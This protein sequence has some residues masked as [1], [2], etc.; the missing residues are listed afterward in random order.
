M[1]ELL[2]RAWP[3]MP[4]LETAVLCNLTKRQFVRAETVRQY[5]WRDNDSGSK[6]RPHSRG[7]HE[8]RVRGIEPPKRPLPKGLTI[9]ATVFFLTVRTDDWSFARQFIDL[10]DPIGQGPGAVMGRWAGDCLAVVEPD[11][12]E[13]GMTDISEE[14]VAMVRRF[15]EVMAE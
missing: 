14:V 13:E 9:G 1:Y 5:K 8:N 4:S 12:V 15:I 2:E 11:E 3:I 6:D 10:E 7:Y